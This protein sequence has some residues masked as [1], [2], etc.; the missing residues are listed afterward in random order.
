[1]GAGKSKL[2]RSLAKRMDLDFID[3]DDEIVRNQRQ[4]ISSIFDEKGET[5]FRE[6]EKKELTNWI[7]RDNYLMACGGGT[8]VF[9]DNMK[10]MNAA[11]VTV[12]LDVPQDILLSRLA[13]SKVKRPLI[14]GMSEGELKDYIDGK[15]MER[16]PYYLKAKL[17]INPI[18]TSLDTIINSLRYC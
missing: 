3:L 9:S 10:K 1:M 7:A 4:S 16:K 14:E 2:G 13:N 15:I 18:E 8:P 17:W 11:G 6:I 5:G 12:Y